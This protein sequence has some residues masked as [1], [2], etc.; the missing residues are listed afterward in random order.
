M[1][2]VLENFLV[3]KVGLNPPLKNSAYTPGLISHTLSLQV[4]VG[5]S[6]SGLRV[7]IMKDQAWGWS[8][9]TFRLWMSVDV[10]TILLCLF[11]TLQN[12]LSAMSLIRL[13]IYQGKCPCCPYGSYASGPSYVQWVEPRGMPMWWCDNI[14]K[15]VPIKVVLFIW[16]HLMYGGWSL[17]E[18]APVM[19]WQCT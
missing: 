5:N 11:Y 10:T 6:W 13:K 4:A 8:S 16:D 18:Y 2:V 12:K 19:M 17:E 3:Y 15:M 14:H 7:K 9:L 1:R